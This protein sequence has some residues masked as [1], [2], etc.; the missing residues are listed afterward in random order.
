[1]S[2]GPSHAT[3]TEPVRA[4]FEFDRWRLRRR[5]GWRTVTGLVV[6]L[7]LLSLSARH[8]QLDKGLNMVLGG[9]GD[10]VGL[11]EQSEVGSGWQRFFR[12]AL[13]PVLAERTSVGRLD[14]FN[15]QALPPLAWVETRAERRYDAAQGQWVQSGETKRYLVEPLGYVQLVAVKMLETLE[16]AL[17]GTIGAVLLAAP[18]AYFAARGY[19]PHRL[20]QTASRGI[21]SFCRS[22]PELISAMFFVLAFGFGP[23]PGI[24]ALSCHT[25][26]F[27]GKFF[28]DDIENT[29]RGPQEALRGIGAG[30]LEILRLAVLPQVLPQYLAYLQYILERNVRTA[31]VLGV[32]GAGG[33][34]MELKGRWDMSDYG[35]VSTILL[36]IFIT[37]FGLEH[38]T[39]WLRN[40]LIR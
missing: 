39:Q 14:E 33:I 32:V 4:E 19:S 2:E 8:T 17:W 21:C 34:G 13:P 6:A 29:D 16:M 31:T 3:A 1:M 23:I 18:L 35:H 5:V 9:L 28:A 12:K 26:G 10:A 22:V 25:G 38:L 15:D 37:V 36:A 20:V 27:L 7:V 30:R 11:V 24:V 40:R